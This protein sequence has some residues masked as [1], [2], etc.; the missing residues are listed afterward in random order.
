M[1]Q[2]LSVWVLVVGPCDA[3]C[4]FPPTFMKLHRSADTREPSRAAAHRGDEVSMD[5]NAAGYK[6][7]T[8]FIRSQGY[9][10]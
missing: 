2:C 1:G 4:A 7:N 8:N 6:L 3:L 10:R 5:V 9:T